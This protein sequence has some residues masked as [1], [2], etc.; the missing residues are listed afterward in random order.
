MRTQKTKSEKMQDFVNHVKEKLGVISVS[1]HDVAVEAQ[2]MGWKMPIPKSPIDLLAAQFSDSQREQIG[3]DE[4]TGRPYKKNLAVS[5]WHGQTQTVLWTDID[6]APRHIAH[7]ALSQYRDQMVGEA[8]QLKLTADHWNRVN[9]H[10]EP[11]KPELDMTP[12]V[13]WELSARDLDAKKVA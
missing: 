4:V 3:T 8:V 11:I 10:D 5:T 13:E 7:K 6:V 2:K 12:D 9:A 1:M